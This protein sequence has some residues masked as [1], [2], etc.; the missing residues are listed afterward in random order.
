MPDGSRGRLR[1]PRR[2]GRAGGYPEREAY[3][4]TGPLEDLL[5]RGDAED[6]AVLEAALSEVPQLRSALEFSQ[7]PEEGDGLTWYRR[8]FEGPEA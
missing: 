6:L 4:G 8:H 5:N 1:A 7:P 3:L 2:V